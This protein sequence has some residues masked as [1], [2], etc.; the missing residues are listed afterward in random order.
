M[1]SGAEFELSGIFPYIWW[2]TAA[3]ELHVVA[4]GIKRLEGGTK[5]CVIRLDSLACLW[6]TIKYETLARS[7]ILTKA[8]FELV[9]GV[10]LRVGLANVS[11]VGG[12]GD[13]LS[14]ERDWAVEKSQPSF[15]DT[16]RFSLRPMFDDVKAVCVVVMLTFP[17]V[18][19]VCLC[20]MVKAYKCLLTTVLTMLNRWWPYR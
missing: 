10:Q 18:F 20:V 13:N 17:H 14:N 7:K 8:Y 9:D 2:C 4:R 16:V 1:A 3:Q 12:D 6:N 5:C 15:N 19:E 11:A